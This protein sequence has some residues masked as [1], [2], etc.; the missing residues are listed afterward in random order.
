[1]KAAMTR[2]GQA[3]LVLAALGA[4]LSAMPLASAWAQRDGGTD[5]ERTRRLGGVPRE[6]ALE[7]TSVWNAPTTRRVRGDFAL[8]PT[9]TV[10]GDLAVLGGRARL[11]GVVT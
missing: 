8:A 6:V 4:A 2:R 9:D 10:R 1:M 3:R 5:A 11:A 7:V